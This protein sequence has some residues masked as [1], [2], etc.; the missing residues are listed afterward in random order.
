MIQFEDFTEKHV[1]NHPVAY[2]EW[3]DGEVKVCLEPCTGGMCVGIYDEQDWILA[4]KKCTDMSGYPKEE[5]RSKAV[6]LANVL[7]KD[8]KKKSVI[9]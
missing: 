5:V 2:Y 3:N 7:Y 6:A 9:E 4:E 8:Y 1:E